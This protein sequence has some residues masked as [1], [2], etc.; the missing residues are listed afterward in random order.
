MHD[1]SFFGVIKSWNCPWPALVR[2]VKD[3][4]I[5]ELEFEGHLKSVP[6]LCFLLVTNVRV[7]PLA[8]FDASLVFFWVFYCVS[9]TGPCVFTCHMYLPFLPAGWKYNKINA[10]VW[11]RSIIRAYSAL[12]WPHPHPS[13]YTVLHRIFHSMMCG[14]TFL[15]IQ[16][17]VLCKLCLFDCYNFTICDI[18]LNS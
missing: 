2:W 17:N 1:S 14:G 4:H 18:F 11:K 8:Q 6:V 15:S 13:T 9:V 5:R 3:V 12:Q 16:C 7:F 10:A